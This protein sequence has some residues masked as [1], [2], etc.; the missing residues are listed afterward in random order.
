MFC[1]KLSLNNHTVG[2]VHKNHT[3][4]TNASDVQRSLQSRLSTIH[5]CTRSWRF[6]TFNKTINNYTSV[7]S[8]QNNRRQFALSSAIPEGKHNQPC[9][10]N[11]LVLQVR[12]YCAQNNIH[13]TTTN[14]STIGKEKDHSLCHPQFRTDPHAGKALA[15]EGYRCAQASRRNEA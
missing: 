1:V 3:Y 6:S 13:K 8:G 7:R 14:S 9:M 11:G 15:T 4:Y 2:L 12:T 10:V 5:G